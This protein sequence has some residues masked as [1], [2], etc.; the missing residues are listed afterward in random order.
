MLR[1][2]LGSLAI[3][4]GAGVSSGC[5]EE[6]GLGNA[7]ANAT[8]QIEIAELTF[9]GVA[10]FDPSR[11]T[12]LL[13]TQPSSWLPWGEAHYFDRQEFEADLERIEA[14]YHDHG[15]P[16]AQVTAF[17]IDLVES[18]GAVDLSVTVSEGEPVRVAAVELEGF[19]LLPPGVREQLLATID[20]PPGQPLATPAALRAR[21][22]AVAILKNH[23]YP[24]ADVTFTR[25]PRAP[26]LVDVVLTAQPGTS[27]YFGP[28]EIVGNTSVED[29]VIRRQLLYRPGDAYSLDSIL[30]SQRRLTTL[31]LFDFVNVGIVEGGER[32]AQ[33]PTRVTVTEGKPRRLLFSVGYGTE[34]K[35]TGDATWEHVN[36]LGGA[37]TFSAHGKWSWIDRGVEGRFTQP[38]FFH[39]DLGLSLQARNWYVDEPGFRATSQGGHATVTHVRSSTL[40]SSVSLMHAFES[41]RIADKA[42]RDPTLRDDLIALGLNPTTGVQEGLLSAIAIDVRQMTTANPL[43]PRDGY[44]LGLQAEQ[45]GGWLP[46][47]FD[48]Y[49]VTGEGRYYVTTAG[50]V[51]VGQRI[52]YGSIASMEDDSDIP[53]F[54]RYF[55]GGSTS[56][57]GWGRYEVSPLSASGLPIGGQTLFELSSEVRF[58]IA[59][60]LSGVAFLDAG[61][62]WADAWAFRG[63]DLLYDVGPGVRYD[64]PIGPLRLDFAYQLNPLEG[65]RV[66]GQPQQRRWRVHF[67]IGQ[68]F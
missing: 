44:L 54:K 24:Y 30:E 36:F 10:A 17:D 35:L 55:L 27:A 21:E 62:V 34:E 28:I 60:K 31:Q 43:D 64:T 66:E 13:K 51:T 12:S 19:E 14:F 37:R 50:G 39:P 16:D 52:R 7:N 61:H 68:A 56:L 65:L 8:E 9:N 41:S 63:D 22:A 47:T 23:G 25:R 42:L 6:L 46:G 33:V 38:Y 59:G 29:E 45:A 11:I 67:S 40:S 1:K 2:C 48:Y 26:N 57:R 49:S 4:V 15:Y 3:I 32:P 5:H 53:F 20:L 58:P 18:G